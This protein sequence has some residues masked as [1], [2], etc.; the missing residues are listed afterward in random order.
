M[1]TNKKL[2]IISWFIGLGSGLFLS[3]IILAIIMYTSGKIN[4][5]PANSVGQVEVG[6]KE[7]VEEIEEIEEIKEIEVEV[8]PIPEQE[9]STETEQ[10]I[11]LEIKPTSTAREI[12]RL[13]VDNGVILDY[14]EFIAYIVLQDAERSL[15]HGTKTF[16]L[17]SDVETVFKILRP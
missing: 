9:I 8:N 5:T 3:G 11:E 13:L 1:K 2:A 4:H 10:T 15:A 6:N 7:E 12:T 17:N 14:D 16:P